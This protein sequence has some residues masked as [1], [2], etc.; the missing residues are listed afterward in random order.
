M[1]DGR[2]PCIGG[3][4]AGNDGDGYCQLHHRG[5]RC[6]VCSQVDHYYDSGEA[7]CVHCPSSSGGVFTGIFASVLVAV[8]ACMLISKRSSSRGP[9]PAKLPA[10]Q[11]AED[12]GKRVSHFS[13]AVG[14]RATIKIIFTWGQLVALMPRVYDVS[15]PPEYKRIWDVMTGVTEVNLVQLLPCQ[16]FY[17]ELLVLGTAPIGI[18][19]LLFVIGALAEYLYGSSQKEAMPIRDRVLIGGL[20]S[21]LIMMC[22]SRPRE[23]PPSLLFA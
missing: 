17:D 10:V 8:A 7:R 20:P 6:T 3:E 1:V 21:M 2:T 13:S 12:F 23:A 11:R 14:L 19:G 22:V 9:Q 5:P 16:T 18:A 15:L 4:S